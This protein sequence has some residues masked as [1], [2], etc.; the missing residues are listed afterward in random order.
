MSISF[1]RKDHAL[2]KVYIFSLDRTTMLPDLVNLSPLLG[3]NH[4]WRLSGQSLRPELE[5]VSPQRK[6][7]KE[8]LS[9]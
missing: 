6:A 4:L 1:L 2:Y 8:S 9:P 3:T 5:E 7:A